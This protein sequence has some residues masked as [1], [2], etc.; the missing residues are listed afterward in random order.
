MS[1][2]STWWAP[3][4]PAPALPAPILLFSYG[5]ANTLIGL[6]GDDLYYVN[7]VAD[8]VTETA[9]GGSDTVMAT[10]NTPCLPMSRRST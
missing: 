5:G 9:G 1:R 2:R 10:A 8:A 6:G 7:N 3:A 4:S